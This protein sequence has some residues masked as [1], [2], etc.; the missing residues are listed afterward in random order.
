MEDKL[1]GFVEVSHV[2]HI[3]I[4]AI[5]SVENAMTAHIFLNQ[6]LSCE[7]ERE[8]KDDLRHEMLHQN[9]HHCT[10]EIEHKEKRFKILFFTTNYQL[11]PVLNI[12]K[13]G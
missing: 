12:T 10:F 6:D 4:W 8:L 11:I 3:H 2:E 7:C 9:I 5:S 13:I 1:N